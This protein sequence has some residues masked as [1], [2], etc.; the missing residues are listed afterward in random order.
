MGDVLKLLVSVEGEY[1]LEVAI[2]AWDGKRFFLPTTEEHVVAWAKLPEPLAPLPPDYW[3]PDQVA[4]R[5]YMGEEDD[6]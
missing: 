2:V 4:A 1:G 6:D 3:H 5:R